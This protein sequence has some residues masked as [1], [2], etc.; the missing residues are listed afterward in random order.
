MM[1][2]SAGAKLAIRTG[3]EITRPACCT[4]SHRA[5][6][7][8]V[9]AATENLSNIAVQQSQS[10]HVFIVVEDNRRLTPLPNGPPFSL[11]SRA[12]LCTFLI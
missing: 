7:F 8:A 3:L 2:T 11:L 6:P 10:L 9:Q 1:A 4:M 12:S 5:T